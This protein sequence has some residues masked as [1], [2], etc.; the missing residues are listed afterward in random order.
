[1][2]WAIDHVIATFPSPEVFTREDM[3]RLLPFR[4]PCNMQGSVHHVRHGQL[5]ACHH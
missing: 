1:M 5:L 2:L 3:G 4:V